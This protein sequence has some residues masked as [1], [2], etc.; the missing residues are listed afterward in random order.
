VTAIA[1]AVLLLRH[2]L[3][4]PLTVQSRGIAASPPVWTQD[5]PAAARLGRLVRAQGLRCDDAAIGDNGDDVV[6]VLTKSRGSVGKTEL[7]KAL[8]AEL[9]H[10]EAIMIRVYM[11][12]Y[13][14]RHTA[15]RLVGAPPGYVGYDDAGQLTE[16]IRR[17][18]YSVVL[19]DE[20]EKAHPDV[21]Q[22]LLQIMEDGRL[23]DGRGK[24]V[25]FRHAVVIMTSNVGAS[26]LVGNTSAIGFKSLTTD[27][28]AD[29]WERMRAAAL[30]ALGDTFKPEFL[31]RIDETVVFQ[32]LAKA[33]I[34]SI[35]DLML[36]KTRVKLAEQRVGL[37][38]TAAAKQALAD[39]GFDA[40][41]GARPLR[42]AI[43]RE[44]EVPMGDL[45]LEGRAQGG[46]RLFIDHRD[47]RFTFEVQRAE[48]AAVQVA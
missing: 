30:A 29:R 22:L 1:Q 6:R 27:E 17:R 13:Q 4:T 32:P 44:L 45:L 20:I 36:D 21:H 39:L 34:L 14:E 11:S 31:N 19:F 10:D 43:Q 35:V 47:G 37:E 7:A 18:P 24:T 25:D 2:E 5:R 48:F 12:E 16:A 33:E 23:T 8:A 15:S 9:F 46:D 40:A 41:Y 26:R 42:R 38:A 28:D 3:A